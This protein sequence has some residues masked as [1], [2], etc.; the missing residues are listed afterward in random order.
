MAENICEK[1]LAACITA[2]C[3][4]PIFTGIEQTAWI[5]NKSDIADFTDADGVSNL[6]TA[7]VMKTH[8]V[9]DVDVAY[10]GYKIT[11]FGKTPYTGTVVNMVEGNVMNK[12]TSEVHFTV[13]DNCPHASEI[14][15]N[16]KDGKFVV[17][18]ANDY[19]GSDGK[20]KYQVFGSKKGLYCTAIENDKYSEDTDG[21]WAVTLTEENGPVSAM[22]IQHMTTGATPED[23]TADYLDSL[24]SCK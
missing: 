7:I 14:L 8:E 19:K 17:V 9:D 20:G 13:P 12:F 5:F 15:D 23:D 18:L 3:E 10:T 1:A 6:Y 22:F 24:V 11:Q 21:G 16:L 4:D 2:D